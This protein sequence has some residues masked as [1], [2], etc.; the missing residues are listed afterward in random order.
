M[1]FHFDVQRRT[2]DELNRL[3][4]SQL[5]EAL[6]TLHSLSRGLDAPAGD[7]L[8]V[9]ESVHEVRKTTKRLRATLRLLRGTLPTDLR[10]SAN[11][12][13]RRAAGHL[14]VFR[15]SDARRE[16]LASLAQRFPERLVS[17]T[18]TQLDT[19]LRGPTSPT[20]SHEALAASRRALEDVRGIE[21]WRVA[22]EGWSA[23]AEGLWKTYSAARR[24][25]RHSLAQPTVE[26]MHEWR[27][28]VK[29]HTFQLRL[30]EAELP[31]LMS[32]HHRELSH[33]GKLLGDD[34]DLADLHARLAH[35]TALE[36]PVTES[37]VLALIEQRS[38]ELRAEAFRLGLQLLCE[39]PRGFVERIE[40]YLR[41]TRQELG[42]IVG[43]GAEGQR[44]AAPVHPGPDNGDAPRPNRPAA[45]GR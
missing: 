44:A 43:V 36:G 13:L 3:F 10:R 12:A 31:E 40:L 29:D 6:E 27:K 30:L 5:R 8:E 24:A 35:E 34:H 18:L 17:P 39:S 15:E 28:R 19:L 16:A 2:H 9:A 22:R 11:D 14:G 25:M 42:P 38:A 41:V 26:N 21:D 37:G 7:E 20:L 33:L 1:T 45:P 32:S 23:V 4:H